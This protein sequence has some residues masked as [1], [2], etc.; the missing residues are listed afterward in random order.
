[1]KYLLD[2]NACIVYL[3]QTNSSI[4]SKMQDVKPSDILLCSVVKSELIFGAKKSRRVAENLGKLEAF[5]SNFQSLP[6]DDRAAEVYGGIRADLEKKGIV[7][8]PYDMQIAAIALINELTLITHNSQE[9]ERVIGL[10]HE[11]WE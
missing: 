5:F 9:F 6:F 7:I 11:D 2:T 4:L 8:G 1:M 10:R 3:N